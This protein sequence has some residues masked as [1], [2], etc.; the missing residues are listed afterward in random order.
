MS[1]GSGYSVVI[2]MSSATVTQLQQNGYQLY[3]FKGADAPASAGAPLVWFATSTYSASTAVAWEEQY[4]GY[5]STSTNIAPNTQITATY[6]ASMQLGQQ[7]NISIGGIGTVVNGG[8]PGYLDILNQTTTPFTCGITV[9]NET[10]NSANPICAFPL[11]GQGLD[12]FAPI[13]IV[14]LMF[15]TQAVNTG[16][17][18]EQAFAP[19]ISVD[20]TGQTAPAQLTFDINNGWTGPGFSTTYPANQ[21]LLPVLINPGG[22][23]AVSVR[24]AQRRSRALAA[25]R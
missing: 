15:A 14:Y 23:S 6:S 8:T 25:R 2:T 16:T 12:N 17:V 13:E 19:G 20:M 22:A 10:T 3:G 11:F 21:N 9:F 7:M 5:T 24:A 1:N 4:G 18:I